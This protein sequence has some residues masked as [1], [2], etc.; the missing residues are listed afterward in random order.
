MVL[1]AAAMLTRREVEGQL[2]T[3]HP[4]RAEALRRRQSMV[5]IRRWVRI[6]FISVL[7]ILVLV[8]LLLTISANRVGRVPARQDAAWGIEHVNGH[9]SR[10]KPS[11]VFGHGKKGGGG[12][13]AKRQIDPRWRFAH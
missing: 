10:V 2:R 1:V 12:G 8:T 11:S 9:G 3:V 4:L 13:S 5:R 6:G 7:S